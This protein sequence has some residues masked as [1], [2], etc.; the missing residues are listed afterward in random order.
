MVC[1]HNY[2]TRIG[3]IFFLRLF[4]PFIRSF[5]FPLIFCLLPHRMNNEPCGGLDNVDDGCGMV[6]RRRTSAGCYCPLCKKL[7]VPGLSEEA[8]AEIKVPS[9]LLSMACLL[10]LNQEKMVQCS[11]CGLCG[12]TIGDPCGTCK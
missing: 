11:E 10:K 9:S 5:L 2:I 7:K 8:K 3:G 6:F 4:E 12:T 1:L